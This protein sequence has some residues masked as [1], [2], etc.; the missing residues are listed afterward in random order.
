MFVEWY[1]FNNRQ[2]H[3][4]LRAV[5]GAVGEPPLLFA[6][7]ILALPGVPLPVHTVILKKVKVKVRTTNYVYTTY[8]I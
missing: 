4:H 3:L 2:C 6:A 7:D 8:I 1:S 5:G